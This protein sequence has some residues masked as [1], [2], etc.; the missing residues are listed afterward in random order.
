MT[1]EQEMNL[2]YIL[3]NESEFINGNK[4]VAFRWLEQRGYNPQRFPI[5]KDGTIA[6]NPS[7]A[8]PSLFFPPTFAVLRSME[9][10]KLNALFHYIG[11]D[12]V[13]SYFGAN[14]ISA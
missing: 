3:A 4:E 13:L 11:Y 12:D 7:R 14:L 5:E 8:I 10:W 1:A 9:T 2:A 6:C